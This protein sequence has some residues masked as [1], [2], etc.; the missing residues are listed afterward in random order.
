M[1]VLIRGNRQN[2]REPAAFARLASDLDATPMSLCHSFCHGQSQ[3]GTAS[4]QFRGICA[5]VELGEYPLQVIIGDPD[6]S[7]DDLN[8]DVP[9]ALKYVDSHFAFV[10]GVPSALSLGAV[11]WL[12]NLPLVG[13]SFFGLMDWLFGNVML[14][15]G[16]VLISIFFGW[17]WKKTES[18]A[19]IETGF[20]GY[21]TWAGAVRFLLRYFCP[22]AIAVVLFFK[23]R[24]LFAG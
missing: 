1:S 10:F 21:G 16:A 9:T 12:G 22:V 14:A 18:T 20:P 23:F 2:H 13:M 24:D 19:E 4:T 15:V 3:S 17:A 7:V 5:S 6:A 8:H 11:E